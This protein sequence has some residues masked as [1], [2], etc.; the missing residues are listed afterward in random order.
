MIF[1]ILSVLLGQDGGW[2]MFL[3]RVTRLTRVVPDKGP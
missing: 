2:V 3:L 1:G